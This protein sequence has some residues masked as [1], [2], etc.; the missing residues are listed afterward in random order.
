[1]YFN[2]ENNPQV[3]VRIRQPTFPVN[4]DRIYFRIEIIIADCVYVQGSMVIAFRC[5]SDIENSPHSFHAQVV[6]NG[7]FKRPIRSIDSLSDMGPTDVVS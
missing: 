6:T 4:L 3:A 1:M 2:K 5:L 7:Q